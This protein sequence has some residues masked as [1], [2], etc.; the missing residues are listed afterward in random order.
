MRHALAIVIMFLA[1]CGLAR[2]GYEG[3]FLIG[4]L[5]VNTATYE[6]L[7]VLPGMTMDVADGIVAYRMVNGPYSF[8]EELL[9]VK[10]VDG[11]LIESMRPFVVFEGESTIH[12]WD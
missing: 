6:E 9:K 8:L 3:A 12:L 4:N 10:G 2:A 1:L 11:V 5:N 7:M